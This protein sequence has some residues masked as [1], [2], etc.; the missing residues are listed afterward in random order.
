M[1]DAASLDGIPRIVSYRGLD[2]YPLVVAVGTAYDDELAPFYQRRGHYLMQAALATLVILL[3]TGLLMFLLHRPRRH[4]RY[5]AAR[6]SQVARD[7][8][9]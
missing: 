5:G 4:G 8:G 1:H 2:D 6:E 9:I 3:F 7:A